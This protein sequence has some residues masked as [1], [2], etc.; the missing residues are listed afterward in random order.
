MLD[1]F[2]TTTRPSR[3]ITATN[4]LEFLSS[5]HTHYS[6]TYSR[7]RH[8]TDPGPIAPPRPTTRARHS[9]DPPPY[10]PATPYSPPPTSTIGLGYNN[11]PPLSRSQKKHITQLHRLL[12]DMEHDRRYGLLHRFEE[13]LDIL[14][15]ISARHWYIREE[16]IK[17]EIRP[18]P[19]SRKRR[20]EDEDAQN[21]KKR[22]RY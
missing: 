15:D 9:S 5:N 19:G 16:L 6:T 21:S 18:A 20:R 11:T 2:I 4:T 8:T 3:F 14:K 13:K 1:P 10:R 7:P 12:R 22:C 17:G